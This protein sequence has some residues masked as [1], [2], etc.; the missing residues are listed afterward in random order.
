M[1]HYGVFAGLIR[2]KKSALSRLFFLLMSLV[3]LSIIIVIS[4]WTVNVH[5]NVHELSDSYISD[6]VRNANSKFENDL[7]TLRSNLSTITAN[8]NTRTYLL[9]PTAENKAAAREYLL[10]N[11]DILTN[12]INGIALISPN[13]TITAGAY[14]PESLSETELYKSVTENSE[15]TV[16]L[17]RRTIYKTSP[18]S[19]IALAKAVTFRGRVLGIVLLD[20]KSSIITN[21]FGIS[22]MNGLLRTVILDPDNN[23]IF[24][25]ESDLN[26]NKLSVLLSH[27]NQNKPLENLSTATIDGDEYFITA[28]RFSSSPDWLN[29]TFCPT[30]SLYSSYR[31]MLRLLMTI[32]IF[33]I[34]ITVL[35]SLLTFSSTKKSFKQLSDH[36]EKI[37]L[38]NINEIKSFTPSANDSEIVMISD[39]I[40]QLVDTISEQLKSINSLEEKKRMD[41]IQILKAQI[42]PHMIYNT[43]NVIQTSAEYQKNTTISEI[44]K[45]LAMLLRYSV[46]DTDKLVLLKNE[47][48]YIKGYMTLM[49]HK[50]VNDIHLEIMADD[51]VLNCMT[52][53]MLLQPIVENSLKHGFTDKPGQFIIIKAYRNDNKVLIKITDNGLGIAPDK[54]K[55]ILNPDFDSLSHLGLN[56]V[57]RRLKLTFGN[58]YGISISS[59]PCI[60]TSVLIEIP[61]IS[62]SQQ[63][64]EI[65]KYE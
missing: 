60:Q 53:K 2:I 39:K 40:N 55:N 14:F 46:T 43:L 63:Q 9:Y 58:E 27:V 30:K 18:Q 51:S 59:I 23:I 42:N 35:L 65:E 4:V 15:S 33:I 17:N 21:H 31:Q 3:V 20:L 34:L 54:L 11:F 16:I 38:N 22:H 10:N 12:D 7:Y 57:N 48:E 44:S 28:K 37:D 56:N 52:L 1:R 45:S 61:Y 26:E 6:I 5:K 50:F 64:K 13:A 41:E 25:N 32:M 49:Q 19:G 29:I 8:D 36:I 24:T 47:F 62:P